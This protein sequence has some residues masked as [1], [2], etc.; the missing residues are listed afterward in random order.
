MEDE[1]VAPVT[2]VPDAGS[3][4]PTAA[5]S[6]TK[7]E[8]PVTPSDDL[9]TL[10][11][12][13]A[14]LTEWKK[15]TSIPTAETIAAAVLSDPR[16]K[17]SQ[18]DMITAQVRVQR[19]QAIDQETAFIDT[20]EQDGTLDPV[21]AE[22]KRR[23][24]QRAVKQEFAKRVEELAAVP[25]PPPT[26]QPSPDYALKQQAVQSAKGWL[27]K[28]GL[29]WK[30]VPEFDNGNSLPSDFTQF[31]NVVVEKTADKKVRLAESEWQRKRDAQVTA[32][33]AADNAGAT[34]PP[35]AGN[36]AEKPIK[37]TLADA[38]NIGNA[39]DAMFKARRQQR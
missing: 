15:Q 28:Y 36:A 9:Q 39:V 4:A 33:R 6:E 38:D 32:V 31:L 24:I 30:D 17:Q 19:E 11:Q 10:K 18:R 25:E 7:T 16:M 1:R 22:T 37:R 5:P 13:I 21:T 2:A 12:Q 34:Q 14:E 8:T 3:P 20:L 23:E 29:D 27:D 26:P 35:P